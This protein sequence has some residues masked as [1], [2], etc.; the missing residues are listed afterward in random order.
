MDFAMPWVRFRSV[1]G[2]VCY[3][4]NSAARFDYLF[5]H[6]YYYHQNISAVT[7]LT[8]PG[9]R[10]AALPSSSGSI[11]FTDLFVVPS[12]TSSRISWETLSWRP[13]SYLRY[14][15]NAELLDGWTL[16]KNHL[17]IYDW[18]KT[19]SYYHEN[20]VRNRVTQPM[21]PRSISKKT[22]LPFM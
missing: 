16:R 8:P 3:D 22:I 9:S 20:T 5:V 11:R 18:W 14:Q 13:W 4:F 21:C 1:L 7:D 6:E 12:L 10:M 2:S 19:L 15:T 17:P